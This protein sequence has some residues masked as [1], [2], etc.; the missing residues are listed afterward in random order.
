[1]TTYSRVF[2]PALSAFP[3]NVLSLSASRLSDGSEMKLLIHLG[4]DGVCTPLYLRRPARWHCCSGPFSPCPGSH[5]VSFSPPATSEMNNEKH[6]PKKKPSCH[7][8]RT[9]TDTNS[10]F[11]NFVCFKRFQSFFSRSLYS[12]CFSTR[13]FQLADTSQSTVLHKRVREGSTAEVSSVNNIPTIR[14]EPPASE[15][16]ARQRAHFHPRLSAPHFP[17]SLSLYLSL[18][19]SFYWSI[20]LSFLLLEIG[21]ASCRER[22]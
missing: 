10:F 14:E 19:R 2:Q 22:V 11:L 5:Y 21:R 12:M 3:F 20:S 17:L 6:P 16:T 9:H 7:S 18:S 1:M 4:R 13:Q 8:T 15:F